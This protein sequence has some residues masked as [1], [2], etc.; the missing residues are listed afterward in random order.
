MEAVARANDSRKNSLS[1]RVFSL[2]ELEWFSKNSY[3]IILK[4]C[5][6]IIPEVLGRL[7]RTS[8]QVCS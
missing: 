8:I 3:N 5:T 2:E 7:V 1:D 6:E 4:Y